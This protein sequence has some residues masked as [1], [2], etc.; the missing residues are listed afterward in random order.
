MGI[1][2]TGGT[3][4]PTGYSILWQLTGTDGDVI[5]KRTTRSQNQNGTANPDGLIITDL[6]YAGDYTVTV[7][8]A[9]G[10]VI[11]EQITLEDGSTSI[12][13][14]S[15]GDPTITQ[16]GCN[17][18]EL[19]SIELQLSGGSQPY[20][21]KWY[22]LAVASDNALSLTSTNTSGTGSSSVASETIIFSD[23]GYVSMNK[24]GFLHH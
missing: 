22:R 12:S 17:S 5:Y 3:T 16:P 4:S 1:N 11:S 18:D 13:P 15:V 20:D 2:I 7:T 24:D 10:C 19:G 8:D 23:G 21:I 6:E 9:A 14:F